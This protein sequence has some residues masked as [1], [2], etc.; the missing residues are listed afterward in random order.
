MERL[1]TLKCPPIKRGFDDS[2]LSVPPKKVRF[3]GPNRSDHPLLL[4][5]PAPNLP[6]PPPT[7][8]AGARRKEKGVDFDVSAKQS[9]KRMRPEYS[10]VAPILYEE[11]LTDGLNQRIEEDKGPDLRHTLVRHD[12]IL[13]FTACLAYKDML[14]SEEN[15]VERRELHDELMK[16]VRE[17]VV[18]AGCEK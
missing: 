17:L 16:A 12:L 9:I 7:N 11:F 10:A 18:G 4:K 14:E 13:N 5:G 8:V 2:S 15:D 3:E 6:P 1:N